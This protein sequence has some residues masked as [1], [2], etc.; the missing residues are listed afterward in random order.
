[1]II[2][3]D[4]DGTIMDS[5][6]LVYKMLNIFPKKMFGINKN[7]SQL[8]DANKTYKKTALNK[9]FRCL[10][11]DSFYIIDNA[12]DV[13][14]Y[15]AKNNVVVLLS[16]RPSNLKCIKYLTSHNI[17]NSK[18]ASDV[19][20]LGVKNKEQF[21]Q[22]N[23]VDVFIDNNITTCCAVAQKSKTIS[24]CYSPKIDQTKEGIILANTWQQLYFELN[25]I[26]KEKGFLTQNKQNI[27][28][29]IVENYSDGKQR[30]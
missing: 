5:D 3:L 7:S 14:N 15:F 1:M 30:E 25:E 20:L 9:I 23:K 12:I 8:F 19:V 26:S 16:S 18:I 22:E 27:I 17:H 21:C 6:S 28:N 2:A 13:I 24:I 10:N 29:S 11:P 4:I